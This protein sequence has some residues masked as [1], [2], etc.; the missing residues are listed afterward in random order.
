ML[1]K[2]MD[3]AWQRRERERAGRKESQ[4]ET[5][6]ATRD[7]TCT[8]ECH[9]QLLWEVPQQRQRQRHITHIVCQ[10]LLA[11]FWLRAAATAT[12]VNVNAKHFIKSA[13]RINQ[14]VTAAV[15]APTV[16]PVWMAAA[17]ALESLP[18]KESKKQKQKSNKC[19]MVKPLKLARL[20]KRLLCVKPFNYARF[21]CSILTVWCGSNKA[22][23]LFKR[24]QLCVYLKGIEQYSIRTIHIK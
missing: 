24:Q 17:G 8:F 21:L 5:A 23:K 16:T 12:E 22:W 11:I 15:A 2:Q 18:Q 13:E 6:K 14:I 7:T 10:L 4:L 20:S 1:S 19:S 3:R 9:P